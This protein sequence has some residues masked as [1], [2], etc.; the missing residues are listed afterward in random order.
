M[1]LC[2]QSNLCTTLTRWT[3]DQTDQEKIKT[4]TV[5]KIATK[6]K[7][8]RSYYETLQVFWRNLA[9]NGTEEQKSRLLP[10]LC[11]G[12]LC[13]ALAM[14]EPGAGGTKLWWIVHPLKNGQYFNIIHRGWWYK[15]LMQSRSSK[16]NY[17]QLYNA[18]KRGNILFQGSSAQAVMWSEV[19]SWQPPGDHYL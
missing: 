16:N 12:E 3:I 15:F 13:G 1:K 18:Q 6:T 11:S 10:P 8:D 4:Q 19:W 7:T 17:Q 2:T 9:Q 14:S 5:M